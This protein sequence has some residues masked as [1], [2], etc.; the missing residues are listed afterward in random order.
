MVVEREGQTVRVVE[1]GAS[2][3]LTIRLDDSM[4]DLDQP[5]TVLGPDGTVLF[6][7]V[8]PRTRRVIEETLGEREDPGGVYPAEVTVNVGS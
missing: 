5:V 7:G 2:K 1:S 3:T 8:V 4:V 6:T